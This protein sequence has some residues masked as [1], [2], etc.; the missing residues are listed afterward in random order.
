[1]IRP[2]ALNEH[3]SG[4]GVAIAERALAATLV[5]CPERAL[6]AL[7]DRLDAGAVAD[8][9]AR[10]VVAAVLALRDV[11]GAASIT[12]RRVAETISDWLDSAGIDADENAILAEVE[13]LAR[14]DSTS[15][16]RLCVPAGT[17]LR[18]A[19]ERRLADAD[20]LAAE[21]RRYVAS[22]PDA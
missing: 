11:S 10:L 19:R 1:M 4:I 2:C 5:A 13:R 17:V 6:A 15:V 12:P 22:L 8:R 18:A 14:D 16:E 9:F 7:G 21:W 20:A 3:P